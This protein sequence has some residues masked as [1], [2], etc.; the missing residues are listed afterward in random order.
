M[1]E[2]GPPQAVAELSVHHGCGSHPV[3]SCAL[4]VPGTFRKNRRKLLPN[5][6]PAQ[7]LFGTTALETQ[8]VGKIA[9]TEW[10]DW[11]IAAFFIIVSS[12]FN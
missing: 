3:L 4:G 5:Y 9:S 1:K 11:K 12:D 7:P 10:N 6:F 8:L 2:F